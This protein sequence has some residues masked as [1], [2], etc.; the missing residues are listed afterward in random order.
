MRT[1]RLLFVVAASLTTTAACASSFDGG[2]VG[3][4]G[5]CEIERWANVHLARIG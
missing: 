4:R 5:E 3:K 1:I 2:D